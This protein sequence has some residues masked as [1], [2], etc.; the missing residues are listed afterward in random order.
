MWKGRVKHGVDR[1]LISKG[2]VGLVGDGPGYMGW[3]YWVVGFVFGLGGSNKYIWSGL[4][5]NCKT[6][7][8]NL[9]FSET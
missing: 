7:G 4:V 9:P 2:G 8:P 1:G 5:C 3:G 6:Q